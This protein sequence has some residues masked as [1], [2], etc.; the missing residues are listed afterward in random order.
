MSERTRRSAAAKVKPHD[1]FAE[2]RRLRASGQ[3]RL[4]TYQ[5]EAEEDLYEELDEDEYRDVVRKRLDEDDFVV[6]DTGEGYADN[7]MDDWGDEGRYYSDEGEEA[8]EMG[9]N[10]KTL[11]K[12]ELK[13]KREEEEEKKKKEEG[14]IKKYFSKA[15]APTAQKQK[16][17][18]EDKE[19]L[20]DLLGEFDLPAAA[21]ARE[22]KKIKTE[23]RARALSPPRAAKRP[24]P[25]M[26]RFAE[27][28]EQAEDSDYGEDISF[29]PPVGGGDDD[30]DMNDAPMGIPPSSPAA[31]AADRKRPGIMI[32]KEESDDDDDFAVAEIKGNKKVQAAK[33][34][35]TSTRPVRP[36]FG[37]ATAAKDEKK[38]VAVPIDTSSWMEVSGGLNTTATTEAPPVP[39]KLSAEHAMEEDGSISMF[40]MDYTEANGS[41]LLFGKVKD[42][43]SGKYVSAFLK[44][45]GILRNLFFLP[46]EHRTIKGR[47]TDEE[48]QME[49]VYN[50]AGEVMSRNRIENFKSKPT[51]RKYAFEVAGVP[52][53]GDY[54]KVLYPYT[55]KSAYLNPPMDLI[56][57][58]YRT[59][60]P[61]G[62]RR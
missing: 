47:E 30:I 26:A 11:S 28:E 48:V 12:K 32:K 15:A 29:L 3:T 9:T 5:V 25:K 34:N 61:H 14:D 36:S 60:T 38:P 18:K 17:G 53:E 21:P 55:S 52:R 41:L 56:L 35:I 58:M 24:P 49:D 20:D 10:G 2:L 43:R 22:M 44:V 1:K 42:K 13:R 39:G 50:E 7:G 46:R 27:P 8:E 37:T 59:R 19:F 57:M 40:W 62:P 31:K 45:D 54:L 6:D 4:S 16:V 51:S 23:K 33:V